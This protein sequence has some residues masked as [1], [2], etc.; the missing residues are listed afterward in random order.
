MYLPW[1]HDLKE[2]R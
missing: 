1:M 2:T